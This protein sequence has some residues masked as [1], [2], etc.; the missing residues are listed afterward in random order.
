MYRVTVEL[1]YDEDL[2]KLFSKLA[3]EV[4][5]R[6]GRLEVYRNG[7]RLVIVGHALDVTSLRSLTNTILRLLY[8]IL[9]T[10]E[11]I[12]AKCMGPCSEA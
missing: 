11:S 7:D 1:H 3:E 2:E 12:G 5:F 6:R 8:A 9:S 4:R 10:E